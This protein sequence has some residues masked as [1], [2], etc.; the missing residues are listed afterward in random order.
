MSNFRLSLFVSGSVCK[1]IVYHTASV[2]IGLDNISYNDRFLNFPLFLFYPELNSAENKHLNVTTELYNQ[3][4]HFANFI[5]GNAQ[6]MQLR[7]DM[8]TKLNE[9]KEVK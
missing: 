1:K 8:F 5:V 9:Y 3:K 2:A 7:T 4:E 6:G